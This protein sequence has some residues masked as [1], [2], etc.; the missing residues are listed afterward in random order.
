[1]DGR[2]EVS[3]PLTRPNCGLDMQGFCRSLLL[4]TLADAFCAAGLSV[5]RRELPLRQSRPN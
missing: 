3:N 4:T 5:L 2:F 1:M